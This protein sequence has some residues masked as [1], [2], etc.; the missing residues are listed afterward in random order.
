MYNNDH[1]LSMCLRNNKWAVA[2][3]DLPAISSN[4]TKEARLARDW[5]Y[6]F[7]YF[8]PEYEENVESTNGSFIYNN[9]RDSPQDLWGAVMRSRESGRCGARTL[10]NCSTADRMR[11]LLAVHHLDGEGIAWWGGKSDE[12]SSYGEV[13]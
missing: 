1:L 2:D 8:R 12:Y 4:M 3:G 11:T 6:T 10:A 5:G 13:A 7:G 9:Q